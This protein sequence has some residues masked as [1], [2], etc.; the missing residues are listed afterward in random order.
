MRGAEKRVD[1]M[2]GA[3]RAAMRE[4]LRRLRLGAGWA[5]ARVWGAAAAAGAC[6]R[7]YTRSAKRWSCLMADSSVR[8][9]WPLPSTS[10]RAKTDSASRRSGQ[11]PFTA[12]SHSRSFEAT[13]LSGFIGLSAKVASSAH[14]RAA[15]TCCLLPSGEERIH[16]MTVDD[17]LGM[18]AI[19]GANK[20]FVS[21]AWTGGRLCA[22]LL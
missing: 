22:L 11:S 12:A 16:C 9:R 2:R 5:R 6:V 7:V 14:S 10:A 8:S 17:L 3:R 1:A 18:S 13:S 15:S 21:R 20:Q 19:A 4:S